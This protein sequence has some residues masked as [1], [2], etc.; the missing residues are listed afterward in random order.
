MM[1]Y[2]VGFMVVISVA[3]IIYSFWPNKGSDADTIKRRMTGRKAQDSVAGIRKQAKVSVA[4]KIVQTVAPMAMRPVMMNNPEE[5]SKLRM[6]LAT[7]GFRG[8]KT[9][10]VFLSSKTIVA[11]GCGIVAGLVAWAR[12]STPMQGIGIALCGAGVGFLLPNLW[13][14]MAISKRKGMVRCGLPDALDM[15]VISVESGLGLDAALQRVGDELTMVHPILSEELQMVTLE[16]QMGI[17]RAEAL[18]NFARRTDLDEVQ[19]V[20]GTVIQAERF[21]TSVGKALRNQSNALRTK[22]RQAA[23]ERAQK[24]TVKLMAPL[25]LFIF[26][27]ILVVL[28]GPAA[29]KMMEALSDSSLTG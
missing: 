19:A 7:A 2:A 15:L 17:P 10:T 29:L 6:R 13:L 9:T 18:Q 24:T 11:L 3:L 1:L 5:V 23:E 4:Q 8:E 14:S 12:A 21:G 20:V 28:A 25:I 26:P 27:A 22:R 16:S